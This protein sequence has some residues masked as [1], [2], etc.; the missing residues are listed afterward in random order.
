MDT[1]CITV[2]LPADSR[3]FTHTSLGSSASL[4]QLASVHTDK[5]TLH[6]HCTICNRWPLH[7]LLATAPEKT[8]KLVKARQRQKLAR[9]LESPNV[10]T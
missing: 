1:M 4:C 10:I 9:E 8:H 3:L 2:H 6:W 5:H 7:S